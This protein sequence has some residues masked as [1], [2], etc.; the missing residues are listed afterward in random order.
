MVM[1]LWTR[2]FGPPCRC[3]IYCSVRVRVYLWVQLARNIASRTASVCICVD[4]RSVWCRSSFIGT[5]SASSTAGPLCERNA[6]FTPPASA[7]CVVS[8]VS[9]WI[10]YNL[11]AAVCWHPDTALRLRYILQSCKLS[12][13]ISYRY[14]AIHYWP[15]SKERQLGALSRPELWYCTIE[16]TE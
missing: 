14:V 4:I 15:T 3:T 11:Q 13:N 9:V 1:S 8:G 2:F 7:V 10:G 12:C 6:Q 5:R 16:C